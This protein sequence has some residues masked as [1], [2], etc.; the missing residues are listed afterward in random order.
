MGTAVTPQIAPTP[1]NLAGQAVLNEHAAQKPEELAALVEWTRSRPPARSVLEIG[2]YRGGT[3]WLWRELW[4]HAR[5]VAVDNMSLERC[6][7]CEHRIAHRD[8]SNRRIG[9]A[10]GPWPAG[11]LYIGDSHTEQT[12]DRVRYWLDGG[13]DFL[14]IDADHSAEGVRRDFELYAPLVRPG[15]A[16]VLHDVAGEAF[17][18]V[19]SLWRQLQHT[20][21]GAFLI[22]EGRPDWGGLGVIPR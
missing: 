8:C 11:R 6:P 10:L 5:I 12:R 17:P 22:L 2:V 3:L 4:P 18:G 16:I 13:C 7:G 9:R 21:P 15:G 14:H 20:E 1:A 19:V